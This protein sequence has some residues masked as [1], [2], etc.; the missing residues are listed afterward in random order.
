MSFRITEADD[1]P[2]H[3]HAAP[4]DLPATSDSHFNDG[5]YFSAYCDGRYIAAGL[6]LHPNNNVMD[7]FA[8]LVRGSTQTC[9]RASRA[10]RP[11]VGVLE[12]GPL[13]VETLE[14][15]RRHRVVL[16][17][18][19][20]GFT[21]DLRWEA[22]APAFLETPERHYRHGRLVSDVLRYLQVARVTGTIEVDDKSTEVDRWHGVRDHSWGIRSSMGPHVPIRGLD[23]Q[24]GYFERRSMRLWV[25]FEVEGHTG[26]FH[27]HEDIDGHVMDFEGRLDFADGTQIALRS[28][29]HELHY[30]AG[31][32]L[33][34]GTFT[35]TD[36]TGADRTYGIE[37]VCH[38]AH[39]Q[40][41]GYARGWRDGGQ[42]GTWRGP[43][44]LEVDEFDVATA[45]PVSGPAHVPPE[46]RIGGNEFACAVTGPDGVR[47]MANVEHV[48]FSSPPQP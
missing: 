5:F 31:R 43:E 40:G 19:P 3:Q 36:E 38:P 4:I 15:M 30:D 11:D 28:V 32:R 33:R 20:A 7:G 8:G 22:S 42:P 10:L 39:G 21:F 23:E 41:F 2:Y 6:R 48:F 45:Y 29:R 16:G 34:K 35:L 26:F 27:T 47:G 12:V 1:L 9:L 25:P 17:E 24:D 13:R 44:V 46:R 37:R 18:N 14:P